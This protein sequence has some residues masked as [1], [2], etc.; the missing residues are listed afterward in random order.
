MR[1]FFDDDSGQLI[2]LACVTVTV[3]IMLIATYE[4]SVLWTGEKSINREDMNSYYYYESIRDR[5]AS[6]YNDPNYL[7]LVPGKKNL[8]VYEKEL[9]E[10]ALLHGYSVDFICKDSKATIVFVDKDVRRIE[11]TLSGSGLCP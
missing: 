6:I 2:L 8:T 1:K 7:D 10:F 3:A 11:E 4:Y 9:K 5:Y